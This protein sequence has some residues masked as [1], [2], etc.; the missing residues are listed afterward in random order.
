VLLH[1]TAAPLGAVKGLVVRPGGTR[2]TSP[3]YALYE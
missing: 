2:V 3:M 1:T